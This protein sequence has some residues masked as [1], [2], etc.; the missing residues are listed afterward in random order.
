MPVSPSSLCLQVLVAR[1]WV[2][3]K[4]LVPPHINESHLLL[5]HTKCFYSRVGVTW[6]SSSITR[7]WNINCRFHI[8]RPKILH[9]KKKSHFLKST[10]KQLLSAPVM[11]ANPAYLLTRLIHHSR[12]PVYFKGSVGIADDITRRKCRSCKFISW[13]KPYSTRVTGHEANA[14]ALH[15]LVLTI[16]DTTKVRTAH[17]NRHDQIKNC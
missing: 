1:R 13:G 7:C 10:S 16:I 6:S 15:V 12:F 17:N 8:G 5:C 11:K 2:R 14:T 3:K 4:Q 9:L